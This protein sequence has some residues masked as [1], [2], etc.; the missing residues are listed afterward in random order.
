MDYI[1]E[2]V[3]FS[4]SVGLVSYNRSLSTPRGVLGTINSIVM[5][6]F[7]MQVIDDIVFKQYLQNNV[8]LDQSYGSIFLIA[9]VYFI[10]KLNK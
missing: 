1:T 7:G 6:F 10:W 9:Y 3:I 4:V 5:G 8:T 2:N